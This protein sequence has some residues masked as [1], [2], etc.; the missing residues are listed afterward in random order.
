VRFSERQT[1]S[2]IADFD[3]QSAISL[4]WR[5][6]STFNFAFKFR[7]N[8]KEAIGIYFSIDG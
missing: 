6:L 1:N 5:G 3:K 8:R 2:F 4:T 7:K